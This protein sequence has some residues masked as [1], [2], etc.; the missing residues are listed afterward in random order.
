MGTKIR[1]MDKVTRWLIINFPQ[2][3]ILSDNKCDIACDFEKMEQPNEQGIETPGKWIQVSM[4][5]FI[6]NS[7]LAFGKYYAPH[8]YGSS[9]RRRP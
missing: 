3:A 8:G 9:E 5:Y 7:F 1:V 6:S 4:H 2:T